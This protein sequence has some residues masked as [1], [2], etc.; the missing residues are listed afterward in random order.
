MKGITTNNLID[1]EKIRYEVRVTGPLANT[2][3]S[4]HFGYYKTMDNNYTLGKEKLNE[5]LSGENVLAATRY[6]NF[7]QILAS[8]GSVKSGL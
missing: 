1:G 3:T 8:F 2:M 4:G 6:F 5:I 7:Y